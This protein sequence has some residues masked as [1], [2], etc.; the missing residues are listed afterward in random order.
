M[1]RTA[2]EKLREASE[3]R[4]IAGGLAKADRDASEAIKRQA[5]VKT[6]QAVRQM[7]T[8]PKKGVR[9]ER[10]KPLSGGGIVVK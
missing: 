7:R 10:T 8:R 9:V 3:M 2:M 6:M 1:A 4:R 5:H